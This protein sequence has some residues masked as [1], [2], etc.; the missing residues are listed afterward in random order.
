M[1]RLTDVTYWEDQW[2]KRQRP[3]RL[4]LYRD[5]DFE[6]VRLLHCAAGNGRPRVLEVGA[7]GSRVLPYL[8]RRF[9]VNAFGSD[10]SPAGCSLLQANFDLAGVS[11]AI[12]CEDLF[13]SSLHQG[14]FDLVF[15]SGLIEH[16]DETR[17][18]VAEHVRLIKPGGRLVVIVPNFLGAQGALV[19]RL[20]PP[21]WRIHQ[22]LTP[23]DL[24]RVFQALGL[25]EIHSGYIGSFFIRIGSGPEWV[26][27]RR[28][29]G[30]L[31]VTVP[32]ALRA[33]NGL[34][35][36]AFR[37]LPCRPHGRWFSTGCFAVGMKA[38]E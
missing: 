26:G 3:E 21:L 27:V 6:T 36:L 38:A 10:F 32:P 33:A 5:F 13:Q 12:V 28:W 14:C 17:V 2:W 18:V 31:Q 22:R 34:I 25:R 24:A 35:S 7:G 16:F 30:W 29:P 37:L 4:R 11:G 8:A 19:R 20:A 1:K 9:G 15:S 23:H